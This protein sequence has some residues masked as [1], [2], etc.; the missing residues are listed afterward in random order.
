MPETE[1]SELSSEGPANESRHF[2]VRYLMNKY[3]KRFLNAALAS[4]LA[5]SM[6]FSGGVSTV[7]DEN[8][9]E[10]DGPIGED[11]SIWADTGYISFGSLQQYTG[12]SDTYSVSVFNDGNESINLMWMK[13]DANNAFMVT[14]PSSLNVG[15]GESVDFYVTMRTNLPAG[16]YTAYLDVAAEWDLDYHQGVDIELS[17]RIFA[18]EPYITYVGVNPGSI[19]VARGSSASFSADVRGENDP[20]LSVSWTLADFTSP[21]TYIDSNGRLSVAQDEKSNNIR[22]IATSCQDSSMYGVAGVVVTGGSY[23]VQT[24]VNPSGA[25][26]TGGS[27]TVTAGGS[28]ELLAVPNNGYEF[29]N[30]TQNGGVVANTPKY[31]LKNIK[32]D[33][34]LTANFKPTACYVTTT[35]NRS[36]AGSFTQSSKVEYNGSFQMKASP[37][38][39]FSFEGWYENDK[40]ISRDN[41]FTLKNITSNRTIQAVF[42]QQIFT[43]KVQSNPSNCGVVSGE[44]NY[45]RG[46]DVPVSAKP[47]E[48]YEFVNWTRNNNVVSE[49]ASFTMKNIDQDYVLI[50]NFKRKEAKVY[51]IRCEIAGG[52]GSISPSGTTKVT[53]GSDAVFTFAPASGYEISAVAVD[54]KQYGAISSFPFTNV[55]SN[56]SIAVAFGPKKAA[57]PA[58]TPKQNQ[59]SSSSSAPSGDSPTT[60]PQ[61]TIEPVIVPAEDVPG[62][63][64]INNTPIPDDD[65][66]TKEDYDSLPGVLQL[67]NLSYEQAEEML[68]NGQE[69]ALLDAAYANKFLRVNVNNEFATEKM[70]TEEGTFRTLAS[71]PN[72]GEVVSAML[73]HQDKMDVLSGREIE[74][75][76]SIFDNDKLQTSDDKEIAKSALKSNISIGRFFEVALMKTAN[77]STSVVTK[78]D[79]PLRI[80]MNVPEELRSDGRTFCVIRAHQEPDGNLLISYLQ[81]L[82]SDPE[83]ITFETDRFSSY[84]I[85]YV[86]G[87]GASH[88]TTVIVGGLMVLLTIAII[89]TIV[90]LLVKNKNKRRERELRRARARLK[91]LEDEMERR[92]H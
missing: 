9:F 84:A 59:S 77:N 72:M 56:H 34:T 73:T 37:K 41:P 44:G 62:D 64:D 36:D 50:A 75:N 28:L 54:G 61:A 87:R 45:K 82:D 66:E 14:Q 89:I 48:G 51:E 85:G 15:P 91:K 52:K 8:E 2:R 67:Y 71:V 80:V 12:D 38:S 60:A 33:M 29:V 42:S 25:G 7:A 13:S 70:E 69:E 4:A 47:V 65:G 30:W 58:P 57:T 39:G 26:N 88:Q 3:I 16:E 76:L 20:D 68:N 90:V 31:V 24:N 81:D 86:G 43:V 83:K 22:V 17:G 6:I 92:G 5:A 74:I 19:Q 32:Q 21:N 46:T 35:T 53:E 23:T 78:T 63:E 18:A 55:K 27:G 79:V 49:N 11:Y 1:S 40:L 10:W